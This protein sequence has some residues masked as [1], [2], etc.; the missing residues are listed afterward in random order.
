MGAGTAGTKVGSVFSAAVNRDSAYLQLLKDLTADE[1]EIS[2]R[3]I[4]LAADVGLNQRINKLLVN[5]AADQLPPH[6]G[7]LLKTE[8]PE[9]P[10]DAIFFFLYTWLRIGMHRLIEAFNLV[11]DDKPF[12]GKF[13]IADLLDAMGIDVNLNDK[14][15]DSVKT[16]FSHNGH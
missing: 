6:L 1:E 5:V 9:W 15:L 13:R 3:I 12:D 4:R 10:G 2:R 11:H 7:D 16:A 8:N 14:I